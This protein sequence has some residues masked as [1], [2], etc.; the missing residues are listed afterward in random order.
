MLQLET[1]SDFK[2]FGNGQLPGECYHSVNM[3][4]TPFGFAPFFKNTV[5][6]A[7]TSTLANM[8]LI[9]WMV[10]EANIIWGIG[11]TGVIVS[12]ASGWGLE[13]TTVVSSSG[14]GL[15]MDQTGRMLAMHDRY[16]SKK[17]AAG[18]GQ[19]WTESWKDFGTSVVGDK[20]MDTYQDWVI[21]PHGASVGILN[22]RD[23]SFN[24][25]GL[26]FPL[27][28]TCIVA[29][30]NRTGVLLGV[31]MDNRSF[32]A[33]WDAQSTRSIADWIWSDF[34]LKSICRSADGEWIVTTTKEIFIT[35]GY[36]KTRLPYQSS[37][38][39]LPDPL[40][41]EVVNN[42][43]TGGT[44]FSGNT[45]FLLHNNTAGNYGRKQSGFY[46]FNFDSKLWQFI[47]CST[48]ATQNITMGAIFED[49]TNQFYFSHRDITLNAYYLS[50]F[51]NAVP[52]TASFITA[53]FGQSGNRKVAES[54]ILELVAN[55]LIQSSLATGFS[56]SVKIYNYTRPLWNH[57]VEKNVAPATNKLNV[58]GTESG[59]NDAEVGDEVTILTGANAG[60]IRHITNIA[61]QNTTNEVWTLDSALANLTE[62]TALI[63]VQPFKLAKKFT[64][65]TTPLPIDGLLFDIQSRLKGRKFL[66][67]VVFENLNY[68][69]SI[70]VPSVSLIYDDL[71]AI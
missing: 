66:L 12:R 58:D 11:E 42:P 15:I 52:V 28:C 3:A 32:V 47:P 34:P 49:N 39:S 8:G 43:I 61:T 55:N 45:F 70:A 16:L 67:K 5:E 41:G 71:G 30:T 44:R 64:V 54:A 29:K 18:S 69:T 48:A 22:V 19:S 36:T 20:G 59:F 53:P 38:S 26:T 56:V 33:L 50:S 60:S 35:D 62:D 25:A 4:A 37:I 17:D 65:S 1:Q 24:N 46:L 14:N 31:N 10:Q 2:G 27:G 21:I 51:A 68:R 23:D 40:I 9:R 7:N 13:H 6:T 57:A 63:S